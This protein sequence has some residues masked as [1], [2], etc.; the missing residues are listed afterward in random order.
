MAASAAW[1]STT[2]KPFGLEIDRDL[3]RPISDAEA[4]ELRAL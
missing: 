4:G 2:M 1:P 3:S